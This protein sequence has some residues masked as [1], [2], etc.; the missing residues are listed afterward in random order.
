MG[1][2]STFV[3]STGSDSHVHSDLKT[4]HH[5]Y[6]ILGTELPCLFHDNL[7]KSQ[8]SHQTIASD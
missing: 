7:Y 8:V 6:I 3:K 5:V 2:K 4:A 1:I